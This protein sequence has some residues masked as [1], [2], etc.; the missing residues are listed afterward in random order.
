LTS[1]AEFIAR[2]GGKLNRFSFFEFEAVFLYE[3]LECSQVVTNSAIDA[4][5][6]HAR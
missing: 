1:H 4:V 6:Y 2:H 3:L 5:F